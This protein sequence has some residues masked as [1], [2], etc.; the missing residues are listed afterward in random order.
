MM[1]KYY[2]FGKIDPEYDDQ[3]TKDGWEDGWYFRLV[4]DEID[5]TFTIEDTCSRYMPI[6]M[7]HLST[8]VNM[9]N[10]MG[11]QAIDDLIGRDK[12]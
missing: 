8:L 7:E 5:R 6:S 3:P 2:Y 1:N 9:L 4:Y 11:Q 10:M 12:V